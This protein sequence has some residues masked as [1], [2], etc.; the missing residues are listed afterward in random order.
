MRECSVPGR[1][2]LCPLPL[3]GNFTLIVPKTGL[4]CEC[5]NKSFKICFC[6]WGK[7]KVVVFLPFPLS[8][9]LLVWT[10]VARQ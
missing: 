4:G 5:P 7:R 6:L 1:G 2:V 8:V 3:P 9:E 10:Q